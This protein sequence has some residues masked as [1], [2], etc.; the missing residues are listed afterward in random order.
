VAARPA[1]DRPAHHR[2]TERPRPCDA[3]VHAIAYAAIDI[4]H[5]GI[6]HPEKLVPDIDAHLAIVGVLIVEDLRIKQMRG[7][8]DLTP[9]ERVL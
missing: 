7:Q 3:D 9:G 2:Q 5:D 4:D 8:R 1:R 6:G